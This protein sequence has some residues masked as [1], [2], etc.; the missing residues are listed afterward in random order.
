MTA[1]GILNEAKDLGHLCAR[2]MG[3]ALWWFF[4][5]CVTLDIAVYERGW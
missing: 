3:G 1:S 5:L 2:N 4:K